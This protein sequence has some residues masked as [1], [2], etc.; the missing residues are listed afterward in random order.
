MKRALV[1]A[2][3]WFH[4]TWM[5]V[6]IAAIALHLPTVLGPIAGTIVAFG[7]ALFERQRVRGPIDDAAAVPTTSRI[8]EAD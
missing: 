5:L 1:L 3:L 4:A 8:V 2:V 7:V 6:A